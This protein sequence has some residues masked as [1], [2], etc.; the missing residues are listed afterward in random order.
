MRLFAAAMAFAVCVAPLAVRAAEPFEIGVILPLSGTASFIGAE[1]QQALAA[2]ETTVN[3][4]GGINGRPLKF[5]IVDDQ[6]NPQVSLQLARTLIDK[7]VS[8]ILGPT[9]AASCAA[10]APFVENTGPVQYCLSNAARP[11][12]GSYVYSSLFSTRDMVAVAVRYFR[13]RGLTKIAYIVSTD[14]TGR[15]AETAIT[16]VLTLPENHNMSVVA[17]EHFATTDISVAAQIARIKTAQPQALIAWAAGSPAG[18]LFHGTFDAGL[19]IP[20][21]TS[22]GNLNYAWAKQFARFLP[23]EAY[24]S[25][26][27]YFARDAIT[28]R[29]TI[30]A[31]DTFSSALT[32]DNVKPDQIHA[33]AWDP[34]LIVIAAYKK[35]G[36]NATPARLR[37]Y[38][39]GISDWTGIMGRYDFRV[40]PQRGIGE[41]AV[42]VARWD[43]DKQTWIGVTLPGGGPIRR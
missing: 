31:L 13:Q 24:F 27:P 2:L 21:L 20:T 3:K 29:P 39:S 7:H 25:A 17:S 30:A 8:A 23:K 36:V 4:S 1:Q 18:T 37:A 11:A 28:D 15:D 32:A 10:V 38:M 19:D 42:V 16:D 6:S 14:T 12:P 9:L 33:S 34:A 41:K 35:L 43:P 5:D 22:P 40:I 26:I